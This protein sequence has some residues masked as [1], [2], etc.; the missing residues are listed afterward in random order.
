MKIEILQFFWI[1][2]SKI[3]WFV[4]IVSKDITLTKKEIENR[5][6][7]RNITSKISFMNFPSIFLI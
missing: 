4:K 3:L 2:F 6:E 1:N 7:K 5:E